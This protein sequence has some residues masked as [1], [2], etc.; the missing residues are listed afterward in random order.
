MFAV[1]EIVDPFERGAVDGVAKE[2]VVVI[3]IHVVGVDR[4]ND[5]EHE[6]KAIPEVREFDVGAAFDQEQKRNQSQKQMREEDREVE[7]VPERAVIPVR[8][9]DRSDGARHNEHQ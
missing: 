5:N 6:Q 4:G 9:K 7:P 8:E 3:K 2:H 1:G